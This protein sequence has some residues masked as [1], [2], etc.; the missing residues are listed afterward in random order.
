MTS[1]QKDI[2]WSGSLRNSY[3]R[4]PALQQYKKQIIFMSL[5]VVLPMTAFTMVI[6][7]LVFDNLA[8]DLNCPIAALCPAPPLINVTSS[9]HYYVDY[10]AT[11]VVFVSSWSSTVSFALISA[12]MVLCA[13]SSAAQ[14]I[15]ASSSS[16]ANVDLPSPYQLSLLIRI[17][18]VEYLSL[19]TYL[20]GKVALRR[21]PLV[22]STTKILS[23]TAMVLFL[24]IITSIAIQA[25]DS[26]LHINTKSVAMVQI[27]PGPPGLTNH[28]KRM[29]HGCL[30]SNAT[31]GTWANTNFWGCAGVLQQETGHYLTKN[32]TEAMKWKA[33]PDKDYL[34]NFLDEDET[35]YA[36]L[37]PLNP[38][39][40]VD[41]KA[42]SFAATASCAIIPASSCQFAS[43]FSEINRPYDSPEM[44]VEFHC[45]KNR[46]SSIELQDTLTSYLASMK[47]FGVHKYLSEGPQFERRFIVD[48]KVLE[49]VVPYVTDAE[50]QN[51]WSNP[52]EWV[53]FISNLGSDSEFED[54]PNGTTWF[55]SEHGLPMV[56]FHC[57]SEIYDVEYTVVGGEVTALNK[58]ASNSTVA[59]T[60]IFPTLLSAAAYADV[61]ERI[62]YT[63][64]SAKTLKNFKA[65]YEREMSRMFI[66][67]LAP[68]TVDEKSLSSQ[69]RA[70]RIVTEVS[71]AALWSLVAA[72][73]A[74]ALLAIGVAIMAW[75]SGSEDVQQVQSRLGITGL[76]AALFD[77]EASQKGIEST[78]KLFHENGEGNTPKTT[79]GVA[80]SPSKGMIWSLRSIATQEELE[81]GKP[82]RSNS[83][84]TEIGSSNL[85]GS[86]VAQ[87]NTKALQ[88]LL[89]GSS[90]ILRS[91]S[92]RDNESAVDFQ[93]LD[94][95]TSPVSLWFE[96]REDVFSGTS[97]RSDV[98]EENDGII[99]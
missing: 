63:A 57:S 67:P 59:G 2:G 7:V 94:V 45:Y 38:L 52:W 53:G 13:Y 81:L 58:H 18:N 66:M 65:L 46:G 78:K 50:A 80:V 37:G 97:R 51:M 83:E 21:D 5:L 82:C 25:A 95:E 96:D 39:P 40:N 71:V 36:I 35:P 10:P 54:A 85:H 30:D 91:K 43:N 98:S 14:L 87:I 1:Y 19:W 56:V 77:R 86:P 26:Y 9:S 4:I 55:W 93:R 68:H 70:S 49:Q 92:D 61:M 76:T 24:S 29:S 3:A 15:K 28:S 88:P 73:M 33:E 12:I 44:A 99:S 6:L 69:Q 17:L 23:P 8:K 74:F 75:R 89:T 20:R 22:R 41:Y 27:L 72:N 47:S 62:A 60:S 11:R 34:L 84:I 79:V 48:P 31:F 90:S 64:Q 16:H 32:L 42:S